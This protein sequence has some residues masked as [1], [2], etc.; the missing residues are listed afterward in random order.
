MTT[1]RM[2]PQPENAEVSMLVTESGIVMDARLPQPENA[3]APM[4][5]EP[6][7][8]TAFVMAE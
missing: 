7:A 3:E 6:T 2:L 1:L 8:T 4:L 5:V